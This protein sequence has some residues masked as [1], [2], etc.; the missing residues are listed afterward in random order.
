MFGSGCGS[1]G[2]GKPVAHFPARE[3]LETIAEKPATPVSPFP[4]LSVERWQLQLTAPAPGAAYPTESAWD[5][6]LL[7]AV[8]TQAGLEPSAALR[9][10]AL[11]TARFHTENAAF[12]DS[13][14]RPYLLAYC[15]S[16]L[17]SASLRTLTFEVDDQ[18]PEAELARAATERVKQMFAGLGPG[19]V[20]LGF[21]RGHGRG[22]VVLYHGAPRAIVEQPPP[23]V[24]EEQFVVGGHLLGEAASAMALVTLGRYGV[25]LCEPDRRLESP[26][27]SFTCPMAP[28]DEQAIVEI[29]TR[30]PE[31]LLGQAVL[32]TMVRRSPAAGKSYDANF[33]ELSTK[34]A[35]K[36]GSAAA[37]SFEDSLLTALNRIRR[38]A[39][40]DP[41][42][43][44]PSQS[45]FNA[46]LAPQ[47]FQASYADDET[48]SDLLALGV[49]A[50]WDVGGLIRAGG[51]Y[52]GDQETLDG[53][54]WLGMALRDP[55]GRYTFLN[56]DISKLAIG[57]LPRQQSGVM[58][59]V[60]TYALF[61]SADHS[62]EEAAVFEELAKQ[63][64]ARGLPAPM[65]RARGEYMTKALQQVAKG[66]RTSGEALQTALNNVGEITK[67]RVRGLV[68]ETSDVSLA[69]VDDALLAPGN[70][71]LEIGV[72]HYKP[73]GGA[74]GQYVILYVFAAGMP[75]HA[76]SAALPS[77]PRG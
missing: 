29:I 48:R 6:Q 54:R 46:R 51:V 63:R 47:F 9:C 27:F 41:L 60:S 15:G 13:A 49:L 55:L 64:A 32:R 3:E 74:W 38:A 12:P 73:Q 7:A 66:E 1:S 5:G 53:A 36:D 20:G 30:K 72:A 65:R 42:A 11:E 18:R 34:A 70:L 58:A 56:P 59:L 77:S 21:A 24:T 69:P 45:Q 23:L 14:L 62:L 26:R 33:D 52:A 31:R 10:A 16:S 8:A 2:L 28:K 39:H 76:G 35:A 67:L 57:S 17:P 75:D 50:G 68:I 4:V 71:E 25:G 40:L 19:A 61:D 22:S 44:E 37:P 43:I